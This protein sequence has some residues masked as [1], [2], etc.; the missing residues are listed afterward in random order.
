M[1]YVYYL[2]KKNEDFPHCCHTSSNIIASYLSVHFNETFKHMKYFRHGWTA[3]EECLVDFTGFQFQITKDD[4][5]KL[6][7]PDKLMTIK[8]VY[9]IVKQNQVTYPLFVKSDSK[10]FEIMYWDNPKP[11]VCELYG[12]KFARKIE[13][14]YT[15]SGFMKYVKSALKKVDKLVINAGLY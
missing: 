14:P 12:L 15:L 6:K 7:D 13:N 2:Y 3:N 4:M 8:D 9:E 1:E 5:K 11:Q 10:H